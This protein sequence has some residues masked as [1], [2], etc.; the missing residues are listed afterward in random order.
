M[1][2]IATAMYVLVIHYTHTR[3]DTGDWSLACEPQVLGGSMCM[4]T[5][6]AKPEP[7]E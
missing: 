2:M 5:Q 1:E 3:E 7:R 4:S 6:T